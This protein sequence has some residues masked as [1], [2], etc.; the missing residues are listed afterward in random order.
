MPS[1]TRSVTAAAAVRRRSPRGRGCRSARCAGRRRRTGSG[2]RDVP[3][4]SRRGRSPRASRTRRPP[5]SRAQ[6]G[7]DAGADRCRCAAAWRRAATGRPP[8]AR[9]M[10]PRTAVEVRRQSSSTAV[11]KALICV[12]G[13]IARQAAIALRCHTC[14]YCVHPTVCEHRTT[15][16]ARWPDGC[17][18]HGPHRSASSAPCPAS[19]TSAIGVSDMRHRSCV[20]RRARLHRRRRSTTRGPLPG[21]G[22]RS[23]ATT[24][25]RRAWSTCG[26][27]T[28][29]CSAAPASSWCSCSTARRRRCPT[30]Q[31]WGEPGICEVCVHVN[32]QADF[33]ARPR[34]ARATPSLM[35]PNEA[36]L[37]PYQTHCGLSYVADPDGAK[38]ELIEWSTLEAGWPLG[39]GPQ[40]VNHVAFGVSDIERTRPSTRASASPAS[41]SSPTATSSRCTRG[42][43]TGTPP[44]HADDAADQPV[45][46]AP[47]SRSST[48]RP[49]PG[50]ARRVGTPRHLRVRHRRAQPRHRR[51]A[52]RGP[53]RSSWSASPPPSTSAR[54]PPGA[55]PTSRTPTT[56]TSA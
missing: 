33:H 16:S 8:L 9:T 40:G 26:P 21:A 48:T 19:T 2:E 24:T 22:R 54:R 51:R 27:A 6:A 31:A 20:L 46:A 30:G 5:G 14:A 17:R 15:R 35:E 32:G 18:T 38:I 25:P 56:C 39:P 29:R 13:R 36:D 34:G 49:S 1:R 52:P 11:G 7:T 28:R 53:R 55:T 41:C 47:S 3:P 43:A 44:R 42:S 4:A 23:P 12:Y 50:H 10:C 45:S 37:D